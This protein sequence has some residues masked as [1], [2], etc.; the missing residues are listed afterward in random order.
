MTE[1]GNPPLSLSGL[2]KSTAKALPAALDNSRKVDI[3]QLV[4]STHSD[5][6]S[7][8]TSRSRSD[9]GEVYRTTVAY[10][11]RRSA[12]G[13]TGN[14]GEGDTPSASSDPAMV[15][16]EC[17][18]YYFWFAT[19]NQKAGCQYGEDFPRYRRKTTDRTKFPEKNPGKL[20]GLCK[21]LV[22]MSQVM[23]K[24]GHLEK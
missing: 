21:H 14:T 22:R 18:S 17:R 8:F 6:A 15:R 20:P 10:R 16:C 23:I 2:L 19:A 24:D 4:L 11:S 7:V 3:R 5:L 9:N 1:R 12:S 13:K